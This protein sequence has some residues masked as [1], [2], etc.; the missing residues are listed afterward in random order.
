MLRSNVNDG[1]LP[2]AFAGTGMIPVRLTGQVPT[3]P[4]GRDVSAAGFCDDGQYYFCKDDDS[5]RPVRAT[6]QLF[7]S[8]ADH[9]NIPTAAMQIV[10]TGGNLLFGSLRHPSTVEAEAVR[11]FSSEQSKNEFGAPSSWKSGYFSRLFVYDA[12]I[13]NS[14]RSGHN[15][16]AHRDGGATRILAIDFAAS[17]LLMRPSLDVILEETT[18][19]RFGRVMRTIHG[20]DEDAALEMV[21]RLQSVPRSFIESVLDR[22]PLTWLDAEIA[23]RFLEF[24]SDGSRSARLANIGAGL[25]DGSL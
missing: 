12:F 23:Q 25:K 24:W 14:D 10:E 17:T 16:V 18:T 8:L 1:K 11:R 21:A 5:H 4:I 20:F 2:S 3:P 19:I 7:T 22:M 6:E 9:V 15:L 13:G